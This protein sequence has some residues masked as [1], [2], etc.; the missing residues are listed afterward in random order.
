MSSY[1][2]ISSSD[3]LPD[4]IR[5]ANRNRSSREYVARRAA[6]LGLSDQ[7]PEGWGLTA[8]VGD[9]AAHSGKAIWNN[10]VHPRDG[11]GRFIEKGGTVDLGGLT[12]GSSNRPVRGTVVGNKADGKITVKLSSDGALGKAG[13]EID[14]DP[15]NVTNVPKAKAHLGNASGA[16]PTSADYTKV[17]Q[18]FTR[19]PA[20]QN[21]IRIY[22]EGDA[23]GTQ[24]NRITNAAARIEAAG[25]STSTLRDRLKSVVE[26]RLAADP[27]ATKA[28]PGSAPGPTPAPDSVGEVRPRGDLNA[29][30]GVGLTDTGDGSPITI[31]DVGSGRE[32][33]IS[34]EAMR[35]IQPSFNE[36]DAISGIDERGQIV[37]YPSYG[38]R[39]GERHAYDPAT[40]KLSEAWIVDPLTGEKNWISPTPRPGQTDPTPSGSRASSESAK[41]YQGNASGSATSLLDGT[42]RSPAMDK[43][44]EALNTS[45][46][47]GG[48]VIKTLDTKTL[49]ELAAEGPGVP[50]WMSSMANSELLRRGEKKNPYTVAL[51]AA[52]AATGIPFDR[53]STTQVGPRSSAPK[54]TP[55]GTDAVSSD[56]VAAKAYQDAA[57]TLDRAYQDLPIDE[58]HPTSQLLEETFSS[59]SEMLR[60]RALDHQADESAR[61][62]SEEDARALLRRYLE[63]NALDEMDQTDPDLY[64]EDA[65]QGLFEYTSGEPETD[66]AI[67]VLADPSSIPGRGPGPDQVPSSAPDPQSPGGALAEAQSSVNQARRELFQSEANGEV[68]SPDSWTA[69]G[70]QQT[71]IN[72][73]RAIV[74]GRESPGFTSDSEKL[75]EVGRI[76]GPEVQRR[77]SDLVAAHDSVDTP[78]SPEFDGFEKSDLSPQAAAWQKARADYKRID[79]TSLPDV[80]PGPADGSGREYRKQPDGTYS[81]FRN[82]KLQTNWAESKLSPE[83]VAQIL[84]SKALAKINYD[85]TVAPNRAAIPETPNPSP[86]LDNVGGEFNT[87]NVPSGS[88]SLPWNPQTKIRIN[89]KAALSEAQIAHQEAPGDPG[90]TVEAN[91]ITVTDPNRALFELDGLYQIAQDNSTDSG[92]PGA[93]RQRAKVRA[94][95]LKQLM[96]SIQAEK[97]K[98]AVGGVANP[99]LDQGVSAKPPAE[100]DSG[101]QLKQLLGASKHHTPETQAQLDA[102]LANPD[103]QS[104]HRDLAKLMGTLKQGGRQRAR[105][106]AMLDSHL[107]GSQPGSASV[108]AQATADSLSPDNPLKSRLAEKAV[109]AATSKSP[110][111]SAPDQVRRK[112]LPYLPG[113]AP[114]NRTIREY[115]LGSKVRVIKQGVD[116]R[117]E[118]EVVGYGRNGDAIVE[119]PRFKTTSHVPYSEL[120]PSASVQIKPGD[121]AGSVIDATRPGSNFSP[122]QVREWLSSVNTSSPSSMQDYLQILRSIEPDGFRTGSPLTDLA[123]ALNDGEG[124]RH[125]LVR[126]ETSPQAGTPEWMKLIQSLRQMIAQGEIRASAAPV[127]SSANPLRKR[128]LRKRIGREG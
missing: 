94:K 61:T 32:A 76:Y 33:K 9:S 107:G 70:D 59:A 57:D 100:T 80:I 95:G 41:A 26:Q 5:R 44:Q 22:L 50:P 122:A 23:N 92:L 63:D 27:V 43:F 113:N 65:V 74:S 11:H 36:G 34:P 39:A 96:D 18:T 108:E 30:V 124:I 93:D 68:V 69:L 28:H 62:M 51:D 15:K 47:T 112:S 109:E 40:G 64:A 90:Y 38:G 102:I 97:Q 20:T 77:T 2:P 116:Q 81:V 54:A 128:M 31:K 19:D 48:E 14:V 103:P 111:P 56:P 126:L 120:L 115:P 16:K 8:G 13:S 101:A 89:S 114:G 121:S 60:R 67:R 6:A 125:A 75:A 58:N 83:M 117:Y 84:D 118:G 10:L 42:P 35:S 110:D 127:V 55:S 123:R 79:P 105:Y 7:I 1:P 72:E 12:R 104:A 21:A 53:Q 46:G 119:E 85:L 49:R 25:I 98:Q 82:G 17:A 106:R 52:E 88:Y 4:A 86:Q 71:S 99:S 66:T 73:A 29:A 87:V 91:G 3:D 37:T 45:G 24:R 78:N